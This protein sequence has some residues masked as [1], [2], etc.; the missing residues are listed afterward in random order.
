[1]SHASLR[2]Q[3]LERALEDLLSAATRAEE[4]MRSGRCPRCQAEPVDDE[5]AFDEE[6]A[7]TCCPTE[8]WVGMASAVARA[9]DVLSSVILDRFRPAPG[10]L[11]EANRVRVELDDLEARGMLR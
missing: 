6:F 9:E 7:L 4:V 8:E 11:A 5:G 3:R 1:M 2:E 10:S